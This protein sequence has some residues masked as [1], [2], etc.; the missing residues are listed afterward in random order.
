[1]RHNK[2]WDSSAIDGGNTADDSELPAL[3]L[4]GEFV[5]QISPWRSRVEQ[6][7]FLYL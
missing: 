2:G 1:M 7:D 3:R 5:L 6:V 4:L